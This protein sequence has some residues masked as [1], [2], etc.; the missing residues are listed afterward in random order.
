M[1]TE[2][3]EITRDEAIR[4]AVQ[5]T[6]AD[7]ISGISQ[8]DILDAIREGVREAFSLVFGDQIINAITDGTREAMKGR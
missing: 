8:K 3:D 5:Q 6:V 2:G 4:D 1:S 7:V